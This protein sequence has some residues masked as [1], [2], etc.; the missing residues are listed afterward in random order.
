MPNR[1]QQFRHGHIRG[2]APRLH[3]LRYRKPVLRTPLPPGRARFPFSSFHGKSPNYLLAVSQ[4]ELTAPGEYGGAIQSGEPRKR[5][6]VI[7]ALRTP[8]PTGTMFDLIAKAAWNNQGGVTRRYQEY[9]NG[10][11]GI[12]RG[13]EP[14]PPATARGGLQVIQNSRR[15]FQSAGFDLQFLCIKN[16]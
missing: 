8:T 4:P 15:E 14:V 12:M 16:L 7:A 10:L 1:L 9:E 5:S 11:K 3:P 13:V 6:G 2:N